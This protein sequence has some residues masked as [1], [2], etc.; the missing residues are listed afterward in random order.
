MWSLISLAFHK[1]RCPDSVTTIYGD[2]RM[3]R[4]FVELSTVQTVMANH[5]HNKSDNHFS[6]Y[7]NMVIV[8]ISMDNRIIIQ[9]VT[10]MLALVNRPTE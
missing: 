5:L 8:S 7:H 9:K 3:V 1:S 2:M 4:R 6:R 10:M